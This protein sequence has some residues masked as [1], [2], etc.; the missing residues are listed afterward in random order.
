[1]NF[2][3]YIWIFH[4]SVSEPPGEGVLIPLLNLSPWQ[5]PPKI[6]NYIQSIEYCSV[7]IS[8]PPFLMGKG[9]CRDYPNY[10]CV[11]LTLW[12][13]AGSTG[14]EDI[15]QSSIWNSDRHRR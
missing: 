5:D 2:P 7:S 4:H 13:E 3:A 15:F 10:F 9:R 8:A 12:S 14:Y 6:M 11:V 1:M